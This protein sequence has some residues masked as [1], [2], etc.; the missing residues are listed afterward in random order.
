MSRYKKNMVKSITSLVSIT[1]IMIVFYKIFSDSAYVDDRMFKYVNSAFTAFILMMFIYMVYCIWS[2]IKFNSAGLKEIDTMD[3]H[4]FEYFCANLLKYNGYSKVTVTQGSGDYGVDIIAY[5]NG[6]SYAI[7]CKRYAKNVGVKAVQEVASG[8]QYYKCKNAVVM[9]N[10]FYTSSA[11]NMA[12]KI[13]VILWDRKNLARFLKE[14]SSID[15]KSEK[16]RNKQEEKNNTKIKLMEI[17]KNNINNG[18]DEDDLLEDI[19]KQS[20][21]QVSKK[22]EEENI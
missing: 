2:Y 6:K 8:K 12:N 15:D 10:S 5:K 19:L 20:V 9:T 3:G 17:S 22:I 14:K 7:Q 1:L 11:I 4:D 21:L 13:G 18:L 16:I